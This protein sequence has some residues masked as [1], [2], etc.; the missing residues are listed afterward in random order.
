MR[1]S[2]DTNGRTKRSCMT[3]FLFGLATLLSPPTSLDESNSGGGYWI[4]SDR[5]ANWA[6]WG[7]SWAFWADKDG[8]AFG[9]FRL[10]TLMGRPTSFLYFY[11]F[12]PLS[13][14]S[15]SSCNPFP[16]CIMHART[17]EASPWTSRIKQA[18]K[19]TNAEHTDLKPT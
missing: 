14:T 4:F 16:P 6:I 1:L 9:E 19:E 15:S 10:E 18:Q 17:E 3:G 11:S 5:F 12:L 8:W 2:D 7:C 13:Y